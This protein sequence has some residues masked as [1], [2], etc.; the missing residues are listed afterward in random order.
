MK[1]PL[2]KVRM[3]P[4]AGNGLNHVFNSGWIGEGPFVKGFEYTLSA[5]I[6][7]KSIAVNSC[8]SAL[9]MAFQHIR[10]TCH[11]VLTT[12][13]TCFATTSAILHAGLKIKWLD[14]DPHTLNIDL[15]ESY[16]LPF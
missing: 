12:P 6:G 16:G 7:A 9:N 13:L 10:K 2:F 1:Y 3:A 5:Y 15:N 14:I 4:D 8:T 11:T